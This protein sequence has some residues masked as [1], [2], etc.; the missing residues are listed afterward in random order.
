MNLALS[1]IL[2]IVLLGFLARELSFYSRR[3]TKLGLKKFSYDAATNSYFESRQRIFCGEGRNKIPSAVLLLHGYS[4]SPRDFE[5]LYPKLEKANIAYYAPVYT[6]FGQNDLDLLAS[7][8]ASD[9]WRDTLN[10]YDCL[11]ACAQSVSVIG[12][13][14]GGTLAFL[15]A[16]SRPV[17]QLILINPNLCSNPRARRVKKLLSHPV[18]GCFYRLLHPYFKKPTLP[19]NV[20]NLDISDQTRTSNMF[21][22]SVLPVTSFCAIS[23]LQDSIDYKTKVNCKKLSILYGTLDRSVSNSETFAKLKA[24]AISF[25]AYA[26]EKSAHQLLNDYE[27]EEATNRIIEILYSK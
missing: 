8:K 27:R 15:L 7:V 18:L 2:V 9:W 23:K 13:S 14:N 4:T 16:Q 21:H 1:I 12:H 10:A 25:T 6:G 19:G 26:F 17:D 11:A 5:I 22:Y 20:T 24:N 3:Q